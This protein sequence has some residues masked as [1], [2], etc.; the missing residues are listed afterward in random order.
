MEAETIRSRTEAE[1]MQ[2]RAEAETM[3]SGTEPEQS[4]AKETDTTLEGLLEA[5]E[6]IVTQM[7]QKDLALEDSFAL[8][9]QGVQMLH[10]CSQ[11]IDLVEK[12]LL[13]LQGEGTCEEL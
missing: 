2:G 6:S 7:Q 9:R 11:K 5:V 3:Q 10:Q 8:Y 1:T 12:Q 13:L 4:A